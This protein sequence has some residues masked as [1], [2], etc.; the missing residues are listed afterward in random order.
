MDDRINPIT[1]LRRKG[2]LQPGGEKGRRKR[3]FE[4]ITDL[5]F[6]L[7]KVVRKVE[8]PDGMDPQR[9]NAVCNALTKLGHNFSQHDIEERLARIEEE[10]VNLRAALDQ[11]RDRVTK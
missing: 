8:K 3:R 5:N 11:Q 10:Y 7:A 1:G 2:G 6:E 4:T 9:A